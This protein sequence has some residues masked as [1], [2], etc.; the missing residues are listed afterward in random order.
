MACF[1]HSSVEPGCLLPALNEGRDYGAHQ[2]QWGTATTGQG[3]SGDE[4][5][6]GN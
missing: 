4:G 6:G 5:E 1:A 3:G 2:K